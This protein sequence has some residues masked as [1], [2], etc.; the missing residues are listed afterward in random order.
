MIDEVALKIPHP[1]LHKRRFVLVPLVELAPDVIHPLYA[2]TMK[3]LLET[4]DD[5]KG[6]IPS[7]G[8]R[9]NEGIKRF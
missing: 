3:Q 9:R 2:K 1:Q 8:S 5:S 4:L 6:V 7:R